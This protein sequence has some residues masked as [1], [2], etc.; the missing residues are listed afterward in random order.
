M[1]PKM[2][3]LFLRQGQWCC[4]YT[5]QQQQYIWN[6]VII[7]VVVVVVVVVVDGWITMSLWRRMLWLCDLASLCFHRQIVINRSVL[8]Q[9]GCLPY[10]P[11][12]FSHFRFAIPI[13]VADPCSWYNMIRSNMEFPPSSM[14]RCFS[15]YC[16]SRCSL[17]QHLDTSY[18]KAH[19]T[20][21][22]AVQFYRFYLS[23]YHCQDTK[24]AR[25]SFKNNLQHFE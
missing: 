23:T 13:T 5:C 10:G 3:P 20:P 11:S 17:A 15:P 21:Y 8:R 7:I 18:C 1:V 16:V 14:M 12:F 25:F 4:C 6:G 2:L 19:S 24:N 9:W 22:C